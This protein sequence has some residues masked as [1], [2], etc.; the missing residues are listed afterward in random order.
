MLAAWDAESEPDEAMYAALVQ[1]LIQRAK[2]RP[3]AGSRPG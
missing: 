2:T 3:S 1:D